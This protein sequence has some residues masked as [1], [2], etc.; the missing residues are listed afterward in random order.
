MEYELKLENYNGPLDKLLEL[1]EE[2]KLEITLLSLAEVT[3]DFLK[4]VEKMEEIDH[5]RFILADFLV[6][7]SKLVLIKS[8]VLIPSLPLEE[9]EESDIKNLEERLKLYQELKKTREYIREGW[10]DLP[11]MVSREFFIGEQVIFYPPPHL[12]STDLKKVLVKIA[13]E[14]EQFFKSKIIIK[15]EMIS[16]KAKIEEVLHRL[17]AGP[18]RVSKLKEG[19]NR[20]EL[21]VLFL[22]ILHLIKDQLVFA[23]Q[24]EHFGEIKIDKNR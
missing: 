12:S 18:F 22:A 21:V 4:Y 7:A 9:E 23:E 3:A 19:T 11:K 17:T 20:S 16:L 2:K 14:F 13:G 15:R 10:S 5:R 1:V 8:R 24:T 6:I